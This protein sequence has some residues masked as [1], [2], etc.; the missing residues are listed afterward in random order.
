V[1]WARV[2]VTAPSDMIMNAWSLLSIM[3][4][5]G[6]KNCGST[7]ATTP[8]SSYP[9]RSRASPWISRL[10]CGVPIDEELTWRALK[11]LA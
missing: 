10:S 2:S 6:G 1:A 7:L 5:F 8:C 3:V 9:K 11:V 4:P